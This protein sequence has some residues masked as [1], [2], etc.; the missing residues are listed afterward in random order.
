VDRPKL[1][2]TTSN[3][4][5]GAKAYFESNDYLRRLGTIVEIE[6]ISTSKD[7]LREACAGKVVAFLLDKIKEEHENRCYSQALALAAEGRDDP[8]WKSIA[9]MLSASA[10]HTCWSFDSST[11]APCP[12][13][14]M[15]ALP[16]SGAGRASEVPKSRARSGRS[17][18]PKGRLQLSYRSR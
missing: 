4:R 9:G 13:A 2:I 16:T 8:K 18:S 10:A 14:D 17:E 11:S 15:P 3:K 1:V 5:L 6:V 12:K 7:V